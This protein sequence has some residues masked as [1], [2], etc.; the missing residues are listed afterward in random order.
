ME[1]SRF[2]LPL[3]ILF[4][5]FLSFWHYNKWN[6]FLDFIFGLL[7][8]YYIEIQLIFVY[9]DFVSYN[10]AELISSSGVLLL[11]FF[12]FVDSLLRIFCRQDHGIWIVNIFTSS[13]PTWMSFSP[14]FFLPGWLGYNLQVQCW[15]KVVR[16]HI[17]FLLFI[18][19]GSNQSCIIK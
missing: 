10:L 2:L 16:M 3:L 15:R 7:I 9:I 14:L 11:F 4:L 13:I 1:S 8:C 12:S 17:P 6:F 19:K 18:L 5:T